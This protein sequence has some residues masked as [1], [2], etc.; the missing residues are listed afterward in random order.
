[1]PIVSMKEILD[2]AFAERYGV[3]AFN[4]VNDLTIEAVLAAAD[5][6]TIAGDP[7]DL[8][9]DRAHVRARPALRRSSPR[10]P[11]TSGFRSPCTWITARNAR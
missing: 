6:G 9:E 11:A 10:W 4:I 7:A 2:R 3:P 5:P 1:M 8:G